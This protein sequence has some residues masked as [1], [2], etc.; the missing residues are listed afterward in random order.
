MKNK[1]THGFWTRKPNADGS[2]EFECMM[3]KE[4]PWKISAQE[5]Q[6]MSQADIDK[7]LS[8]KIKKLRG[9]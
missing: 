2:I 9:R 1:C 7:F 5:A 4:R 8:Q 3:C 6:K